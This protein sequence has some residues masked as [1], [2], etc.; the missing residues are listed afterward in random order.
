MI[1]LSN[2]DNRAEAY[3]GSEDSS[4]SVFNSDDEEVL[5]MTMKEGKITIIAN[6]RAA[7]STSRI[8]WRTIGFTISRK[9][10]NNY[11]YYSSKFNESFNGYGPV[12]D[13]GNTV[14]LMF[15]EAVEKN[16]SPPVGGII[17]TTLKFNADKISDKLNDTFDNIT[18]NTP[19]YL[20]AIFQTYYYDPDTKKETGVHRAH[21]VNWKDI[22][23]AEPWSYRDTIDDF[24]KYYNMKLLFK[25]APQE[26]TLY[27]VNDSG[28][29]IKS[30]KDLSVVKPGKPVSWSTDQTT[31]TYQ[32]KE[33]ELYKYVIKR[34]KND[35]AIKNGTHSIDDADKCTIDRIK[36]G[37]VTVQLGGMNIY[38][39]YRQ[40]ISGAKIVINAVDDTTNEVIKGNLY[41]GSITAGKKFTQPTETIN[42]TIS[43]QGN[44]YKRTAR[45]SYKYT[46]STGAQ[47]TVTG[48]MSAEDI[49]LT[50]T[51]PT[52][53]KAGSTLEV[54]IYYKK[55]GEAVITPEDPEIEI[56]EKP[57][58][59]IP[60]AEDPI[61][62][63]IDAP[64][65]EGV[66]DGD[67]YGAKYFD[68][69]KGIPTTESQYV[70]VRTKDYL[71]GY[72][73]VNRTGKMS[74]SVK[75][76]K[77]YTLEYM[78]ATPVGKKE[79]PKKVTVVEPRTQIVTVERA[80]SYWEIE[81]LDYYY[82]DMARV[83]NYSLPGGFVNL[84]GNL[85][86][87]NIPTL[88]TWHSES[89]LAHVMAP[90]E[91]ATGITINGGTISTTSSDKPSIPYEDLSHYAYNSTGEVS[92][93]N[94][95]I[96]FNGKVVLSDTMRI[97]IAPSPNVSSF[98]QCSGNCPDKG[99]YT[100]NWIIDAEKENGNYSSTGNVTYSRHPAS[101][102]CH[103]SIKTFQVP[104]NNVIIHTPVICKPE[105]F[106]DNDKWTQLI[107]PMEGAVQ[108]VLDPDQTLN[109]F[110]VKISN[111][112]EHSDR[113]GYHIRDFSRS[114]IDPDHVSY[115]AK[116]DGVVRN[117][118]RFP[119]DVYIDI[120]G[121]GRS[122]N[123]IFL[124]SGTWYILGRDTHRFYVPMWVQ[125]GVY[126]AEFRSIAV[127]G[128]TKL[129]KTGVIR[130]SSIQDYVATSTM[131]FEISGRIYG[132]A[133][134][135]ISD[136]PK[137]E[138]VFR[139]KDTMYL[140]YFD[141]AVDGT[142][143]NGF[144][145]TY[146][147]YYTVGTKDQYGNSTDRLSKY[148]FP[149]VNG[150]HPL[151]KNLGVIKAGYSVRFRLDTTGDMYGGLSHIKIVPTF[152][153]V[154]ANGKN[155]QQVDLYYSETVNNK[156]YHVVKVGAGVDL[157]NIKTG[158]MD[159]LYNRIPKSEIS[160]TAKV[161]N[162]TYERVARQTG[163]MYSYSQFRLTNIFRTFIGNKYANM[164]TGLASYE[165]VKEATKLSKVGLS[166]YMQRWYGNYKLP[167]NV[168]AVPSGYDV[169][170]YMKD[171]GIDYNESFWLKDGYIIVNF[172]ITTV[173]KNGKERLSYINANNYLKNG[174]CSMWVT[175]G[176]IVQKMDYSGKV[177][178]FK[179]GDFLIYY[180]NKKYSDD[181]QGMLY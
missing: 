73:L 57:V 47:T 105:V 158:S 81:H 91:V 65:P 101:V 83:Y 174:N 24:S 89:L 63:G 100:E 77:N 19:I 87:L 117:E 173:D 108:V 178:D 120:Q 132:L 39:Y 31:I 74:Y 86:F 147:Y 23:T 163:P 64:S 4:Y 148:T 2:E 152:Y 110:T 53:L 94:D 122:E 37:S 54:S 29:E 172:K 62:V 85:S 14:E 142:K 30:K 138:N 156:I 177:F 119:F 8:R 169:N 180:L 149:L 139:L 141:G 16:T 96:I 88:S 35:T 34:K 52:N 134:Y 106:Y 3:N 103:N 10:V 140:K 36:N 51:I 125:E 146:A 75:V 135:D 33:Y 38:L 11:T 93:R 6:S 55:T 41:T 143:V 59:E 1:L 28:K 32:D 43:H 22:V 162:T 170:G 109:D 12:S 9:P 13:A 5:K 66:I 27:F 61:Y 102:N 18:E 179:A 133:L 72:S 165:I 80:Y 20:H 123:D 136:Y 25:P 145:E 99:F 155:R 144:N 17:T 84:S 127:N 118:V 50:F 82:A 58:I 168:H 176:A 26:N 15:T 126:T 69:E 67:K 104:V 131:N 112:L 164:I 181:Y 151:Y 161:L 68:S 157:V 166:Q 46:K 107:S 113:L 154:D 21:I 124:K 95:S 115:I 79:K 42:K 78:T 44:K 114:L 111:T 150:S 137:W 167:T 116:K 129:D 97:K 128:T 40:V 159:N 60:E 48:T 56:P 121:D 49:P 130:N 76:T 92:V 70:Y 90:E 175:E 153:H 160:N 7:A 171:H 45:Y 98:V 71:L